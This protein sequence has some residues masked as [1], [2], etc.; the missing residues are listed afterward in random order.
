MP[1]ASKQINKVV[2]NNASHTIIVVAGFDILVIPITGVARAGVVVNL[3]VA[4][5]LVVVSLKHS[6]KISPQGSSLPKI[7]CSRQNVQL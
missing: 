5:C 1:L 7:A 6:I 3:A 4:S 2:E